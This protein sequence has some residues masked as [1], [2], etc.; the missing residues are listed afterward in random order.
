MWLAPFN[1]ELIILK[2]ERTQVNILACSP[3]NIINKMLNIFYYTISFSFLYIFYAYTC[4]CGTTSPLS[5]INML[6]KKV[7]Q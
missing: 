7:T 3:F 1:R 2:I 4:W 6:P 5:N